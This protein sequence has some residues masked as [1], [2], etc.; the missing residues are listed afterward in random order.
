MALEKMNAIVADEPN[1]GWGWYQLCQWCAAA[2]QNEE[3]RAAATEL[4]RISPESALAWNH[5]G[6]SE[7]VLHNSKRAEECFEKALDLDPGN[8]F[9]ALSMID[10]HLENKRVARAAELLESAEPVTRHP[11]FRLKRLEIALRRK[12]QDEAT[13]VMAGLAADPAL[14]PD[15]VQTAI[16]RMRQTGHDAELQQL[17]ERTSQSGTM[18]PAAAAEQ[19][20]IMLDAKKWS[21]ALDTIDKLRA[22]ATEQAAHAA[23]MSFLEVTA[24]KRE[25]KWL[26]AFGTRF[27]GWAL[28]DTEIWGMTGYALIVLRQYNRCI[29]TMSGWANRKGLRPAMLLNLALSYRNTGND[30]EA[31]KV[32]EFAL[33]LPEDQTTAEHQVWVALDTALDGNYERADKRISTVRMD[34]LNP[35]HQMIA[36]LVWALVV[37]ARESGKR[38]KWRKAASEQLNLVIDA[39]KRGPVAPIVAKYYAVTVRKLRAEFGRG[40]FETLWAWRMRSRM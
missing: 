38:G 11:A 33:Q 10:L 36:R 2:G 16:A 30:A 9:A 7:T 23:A 37:A 1:Y 4:V 25:G 26:D 22:P 17:L 8:V 24:N 34:D 28:E 31:A 40:M 5:L 19:I 15:L 14:D 39:K 20:R 35:I 13:H 27:P 6:E 3:Y 12:Q 21:G 29:S 18:N 32:N